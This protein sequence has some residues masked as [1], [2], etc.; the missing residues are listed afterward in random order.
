MASVFCRLPNPTYRFA[1]ILWN[2]VPVKITR[3][4]FTHGLSVHLRS[5]QF[6][7]LDSRLLILR[8]DVSIQASQAQ[9]I[10]AIWIFLICRLANPAA[11]FHEICLHA[12]T[13]HVHNGYPNVPERAA[14]ICAFSVPSHGFSII[15]RHA[16]AFAVL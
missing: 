1:I 15:L 8:K 6:K 5:G 13:I 16:F 9:V 2:T 12:K 10:L 7:A 14:L 11:G 4:Q 3:S